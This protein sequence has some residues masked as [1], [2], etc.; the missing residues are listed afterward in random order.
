[1]KSGYG[2]L[3]SD[4]IVRREFMK[5]PGLIPGIILFFL[6]LFTVLP[7]MA[8]ERTSGEQKSNSPVTNID[9]GISELTMEVGDTYTFTVSYGPENNARPYLNWYSSDENVI[10]IDGINSTVRA[11]SPGYAVIYTESLDYVS[12]AVCSVQVNGTVGK[13]AA[14]LIPGT[15][16][17]PLSE[18]ERTKITSG[19]LKSFMDY[20]LSTEFSAEAYQKAAQREFMIVADVVPGTEKAESQKALSLGMAAS[21]PLENLNMVTIQGTFEQIMT[22]ASGDPNLLEIF[23]GELYFLDALKTDEA[24]AADP[25]ATQKLEGY[26]ELITH[27]SIPHN[28]GYTGEGTTIAVLDTGLN[29]S[30]EQ[31]A[32]RVIREKCFTSN[33]TETQEGTQVNTKAICKGGTTDSDSALPDFSGIDTSVVG[34]K[35]E[36]FDFL[37]GSHTTGIAAGRD[38]IAPDANIVA[39][40]IFSWGEYPCKDDEKLDPGKAETCFTAVE[41]TQD[42]W[43]AYDYIFGLHNDGVRI[44]V[45]NMSY[46]DNTGAAGTGFSSICDAVRRSDAI[47]FKRLTEAGIIL[48]AAS[49][50]DSFNNGVAHP[51]CV[52][53]VFSVGACTKYDDDPNT[54]VYISKFSNHSREL[55]DILAPGNAIRSASL[56]DPDIFEEEKRLVLSSN[57]YVKEQGTSMSAP[58]VSGAF[59]LLK[60]AVPGRTAAE[61][62]RLLLEISRVE[63][64][65][66]KD[67][68]CTDLKECTPE[69]TFPFPKKVLN[70]DEFT[71][72]PDIIPGSGTAATQS[73]MLYWLETADVLPKTGFSA[74]KPQKLSAQPLSIDYKP[75]YLTIQLQ[76]LDV[77]SD[78]VTVPFTD[79]EYPVD[80]LGNSVGMLEGSSLPGEGLT[81]LSGHNH[82]NTTEAGP[83]AFLSSLEPEDRIMITDEQGLMQIWRVYENAKI[84]ADGFSGIAGDVKDNALVLLTCEDEAPEGGYLNRRVVLA[85]QLQR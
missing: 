59:A 11:L 29:S 16:L 63:A 27:V 67:P 58:M 47:K 33:S 36:I 69:Y 3:I 26:T 57:S 51:A 15:E 4:Q 2:I 66:R 49:G 68:K 72:L 65:T 13:D 12:H 55:V 85:E 82:L 1:M 77:A 22:F 41:T 38:G 71:K 50:N 32:R 76:T 45:V 60:Q 8:D 14:D 54:P 42:K 40:Q 7:V 18:T 75:T 28:L 25:S 81:V 53:D 52:S 20:I 6:M 80:W 30:H 73:H 83:F 19:P 56:Y 17:V 70:F 21:Y 44:D 39:V 43:R 37:H 74:L 5:K 84:T 48:V 64:D 24:S 34:V 23:G 78:I 10:Q 79:G 9:L 61:Y 62:K 35:S 46:G 31:F